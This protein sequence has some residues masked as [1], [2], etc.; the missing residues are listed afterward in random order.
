MVRKFIV[1]YII[2]GSLQVYNLSILGN[3]IRLFH[4]SAIALMIAV[5]LF[6]IIYFKTKKPALQF[7]MPIFLIFIE[8]FVSMF[9]A[10]LSFNQHVG[11][12]LYAQRDIYFYLFYFTLHALKIEKKDLMRILIL[13]GF[14]YFILYLIQYLAYP[15]EILDIPMRIERGTIRIYLEGAGYAMISYFMCLQIFYSTNKIKY[16][17][18]SIIFIL[19]IVLFGTR[20]GLATLLVG[21]L[22]QLILSKKVKSKALIVFLVILSVIPVIYFFQ[23]IF[24]GVIKAQKV[25][26]AQGSENIRILAAQFFLTKLP[27]NTMAYITGIGA[28]SERSSLGQL[29]TMLSEKYGFYLVDVGI[30]GNYITYGVLFVFS[31]LLIVIKLMFAKMERDMSFIKYFFFFEVFLMLPI[32]AGFAFS[33]PIATLC[34][35]FYLTDISSHER[36]VREKAEIHESRN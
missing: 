30:I 22:V 19:P 9:T 16:L 21:T 4:L 2:I 13:F 12:S 31:V 15:A 24:S 11:I 10:F 23:D 27:P 20:S 7:A 33:P 35:L 25:E 36:K 34:C 14:L 1:V 32:A 6:D 3:I 26:N 17:I 8:V 28:P 29:T 18:F 5:I